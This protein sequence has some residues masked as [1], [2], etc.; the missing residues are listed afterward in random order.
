MDHRLSGAV[1]V[2]SL[3]IG[4]TLQACAAP[5]AGGPE[6]PQPT[7]AGLMAASRDPLQ[8]PVLPPNPNPAQRGEL[9]YYMN[10]MPCH[11]DVG[12][13]LTDAWRQVWVED[14]Q[15]CWARG[16]HG[17]RVE[18][19][20]FPIPRYVPPV[21]NP[22]LVPGRFKDS[23][24]LLA[25][26]ETTHPPQRPGALEPQVYADMVAFLLAPHNQASTSP[27]V[28]AAP[29]V[30]APVVAAP[31]APPAASNQVALISLALLGLTLLGA[32]LAGRGSGRNSV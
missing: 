28:A 26:L 31:A 25:Y 24:A 1:I 3:A 18:D 10:C 17:G 19:G 6:S 11:G 2:I 15:N 27:A 22:P 4:L 12:Q 16:C 13:G 20:G 8:P 23:A 9:D 29:V 32:W 14:H 7:P 30:A 5:L 21:M